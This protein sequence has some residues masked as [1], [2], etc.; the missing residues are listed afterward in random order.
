MQRKTAAEIFNNPQA[1]GAP[2]I[3]EIFKRNAPV[4]DG[5]IMG[6]KPFAGPTQTV[7]PSTPKAKSNWFVRASRA[8]TDFFGPRQ[9]LEGAGGGVGT[10]LG[11]KQIQKSRD[12]GIEIMNN[13]FER[14]M[15][16][17]ESGEDTT[18]LRNALTQLQGADAQTQQAVQDLLGELPTAKQIAGSAARTAATV[19][20]PS[21]FK[22]AAGLTGVA[23]ATTKTQALLRG[24]AA[25][26]TAAAGLGAVQGA[27]LAAERDDDII[28]GAI[29]GGVVG[30]LVSG[31]VGGGLSAR[32]LGK[33]QA[34]QRKLE[35]LVAPKMSVKAR[36]AAIAEGRMQDAG[37]V[38]KAEIVA[39]R[40][41]KQL[42]KAVEG[43]VKPNKPTGQNVEAIK[44]ETARIAKGVEDYV[45]KNKVP[46]NK[47]QLK[48]QL[49][50]G[51]DELDLIFAS[52]S[53]AKKTY[54]ALQKAFLKE[55]KKGDT[56][57]LFKARQSF[58]D[59]PAVKKLLQ[60]E[61]FGE[62]TRK[63][64]V[65]AIRKNANRFIADLL[66]QGNTYKADMLKEH[67][68]YE[69]RKNIS[70]KATGELGK[71]LLDKLYK[72]HP[73]LK[74]VAGGASVGAAGAGAK[75]LFDR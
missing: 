23:G 57:G 40:R 17:E 4:G 15:E 8:I 5:T 32:A 64:L 3:D 13:L 18:R 59:L 38:R 63:E 66:P 16:K 12:T 11:M 9:L 37:F 71:T 2:S 33:Q 67:L 54:D 51:T 58:D 60:T 31:V 24:G 7:T 19:L 35:Q 74:W 36:S 53:S 61:T 55:V 72:D 50:K 44:N 45:S 39:G 62:N 1:A 46:F 6:A 69:A 43:I 27:G 75:K 25:A 26:T 21:V 28:K 42:A 65:L 47:A 48:T 73:I 41:E 70:D 68:L 52:D 56:A 14:I 49:Q 34:A 29:K 22:K 30:G 20:T 10:R